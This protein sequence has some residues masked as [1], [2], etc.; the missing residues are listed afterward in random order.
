M[1]AQTAILLISGSTRAESTNT[2]TLRTA[3]LSDPAESPRC[4]MTGS[5]ICRHSAR[6]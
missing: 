3:H 2:A 4:S 5:R 6:T 1:S